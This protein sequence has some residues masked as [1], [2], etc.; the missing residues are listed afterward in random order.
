MIIESSKRFIEGYVLRSLLGYVMYHKCYVTEWRTE[1]LFL[2]KSISVTFEK[3][4]ILLEYS[5]RQ[6]VVSI[7]SWRSL[8]RIYLSVEI[9][10]ENQSWRIWF[11]DLWDDYKTLIGSKLF[12]YIMLNSINPFHIKLFGDN[13]AE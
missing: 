11:A 5:F 6:T 13:C 3:W 9:V 2:T 4:K 1:P 7:Y 12:R 8:G 10:V